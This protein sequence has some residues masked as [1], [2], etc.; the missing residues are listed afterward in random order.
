[1]EAPI[2]TLFLSKQAPQNETTTRL[3]QKLPLKD[4]VVPCWPISSLF[5][6]VTIFPLPLC[7]RILPLPFPQSGFPQ[8]L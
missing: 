2:T 8:H 1:M 6:V 3:T 7:P 4:L 5:V